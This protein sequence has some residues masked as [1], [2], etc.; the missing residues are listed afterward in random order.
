ML[1]NIQGHVGPDKPGFI[2]PDKQPA[3][4]SLLIKDR[5]SEQTQ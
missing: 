2:G 3:E 1:I 4:R 5:I